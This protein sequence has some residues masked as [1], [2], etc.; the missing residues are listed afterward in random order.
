[1]S[2]RDLKN[3]IGA[4]AASLEA[5]ANGKGFSNLDSVNA[6]GRAGLGSGNQLLSSLDNAKNGLGQSFGLLGGHEQA[7]GNNQVGSVPAGKRFLCVLPA[8]EGGKQKQVWPVGIYV[9]ASA[10]EGFPD[11]IRVYDARNFGASSIVSHRSPLSLKA[12]IRLACR[13]FVNAW[14][15]A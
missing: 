4:N 12:R 5:L 15:A 10:D 7:S 1:M 2:E 9:R 3:F 13:A 14:R 8:D 11:V 6:L